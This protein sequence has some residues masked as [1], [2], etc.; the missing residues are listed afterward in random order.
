MNLRP[1]Q[2]S[3][4]AKIQHAFAHEDR[5]RVLASQATGTGKT[6]VMGELARRRG[7]KTL[8]LAHR[9]ELIRQ[10][11]S[12][13]AE[14]TQQSVGIVK[15][16]ENSPDAK[17]VVASVQTLAHRKR[18]DQLKGY[19]WTTIMVDEAHHS[20]AATYQRVLRELG[21]F[22]KVKT[23]GVTATPARGDKKPLGKTWEKLIRGID[24]KE[25][26]KLGFLCPPRAVVVKLKGADFRKIRTTHGQLRDEDSEA[27]LME[28]RAPLHI[29]QAI[30][31]LALNRP[32]L[33]FTPSVKVAYEVAKACLRLKMTAEVVEGETELDLRR[34][35]LRRFH[36]GITH[37][38]SNC[39]VL[40]EGYDEEKVGCIVM[41][42][43]T[44]SEPFYIQCIGRGTRLHPDKEDCLIIDVVGDTHRHDL[45]RAPTLFTEL[46]GP[47][48]TLRTFT[49]MRDAIEEE[50]HPE[51]P[52]AKLHVQAVDLFGVR[53]F[54]WVK[55][56]F[57]YVIGLGSEEGYAIM[58]ESDAGWFVGR[59][60]GD[61]VF[62][63]WEG[64][65]FGYAQGQAEDFIRSTGSDE[66]CRRSAPWRNRSMSVGQA[67]MLERWR[68]PY[69][70]EMTKGEA[71]DQ[72]TKVM[73]EADYRKAQRN[74]PGVWKAR[75]DHEAF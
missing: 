40:V 63:V 24:I 54:A 21:S 12:K 56:N 28:A 52:D 33:V 37:V 10:A 1:Y 74:V 19:D 17:V 53:P 26:V 64:E 69:T 50:Q 36:V 55:T 46:V 71:A 38:L 25:G 59:L 15:A 58:A 8:V 72:I 67:Q 66:I 47:E 27:V 4:L 48:E 62:K 32:T 51:I 43:P 39:A 22:D 16:A 9:D 61:Q 65:S 34:D 41:A 29:A 42:R 23:L 18:L 45:C 14:I 30:H 11:A 2:T 70:D 7:G 20:E 35:A 60:K 5:T 3:I 49:V 68:E 31:Q 44:K 57:G 6:V 73:A 75:E 13:F